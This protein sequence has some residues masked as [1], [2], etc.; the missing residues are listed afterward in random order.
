MPGWQN[1]ISENWRLNCARHSPLSHTLMLHST[2]NSQNSSLSHPHCI[3]YTFSDLSQDLSGALLESFVIS[4]SHSQNSDAKLTSSPNDPR[5]CS[6]CYVCQPCKTLQPL[7][8]ACVS[9]PWPA[10]HMWGGQITPAQRHLWWCDV[11]TFKTNTSQASVFM[12]ATWWDPG[13]L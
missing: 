3:L 8:P 9:H 7:P 10:G 1:C 11:T 13:H 4:F 12:T 2:Q 5:W 6:I